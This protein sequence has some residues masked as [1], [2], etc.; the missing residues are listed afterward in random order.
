MTK[1]KK[2][3]AAWLGLVLTVL[4]IGAAMGSPLC[5]AILVIGGLFAAAVFTIVAILELLS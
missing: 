4:L 5:A 3:A 2:I 1:S